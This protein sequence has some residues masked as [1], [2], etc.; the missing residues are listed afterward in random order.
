M[1][2]IASAISRSD[3]S[4]TKPRAVTSRITASSSCGCGGGS[5]CVD[6]SFV[7]GAGGVGRLCV[8]EDS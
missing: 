4:A 8:S 7:E 3:G 1:S 2:N 5:S 6:A